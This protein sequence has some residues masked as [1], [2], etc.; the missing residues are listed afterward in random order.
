MSRSRVRAVSLAE[1][2]AARL[3]KMTAAGYPGAGGT[4]AGRRVAAAIGKKKTT[5]ARDG[6]S[7]VSS[8]NGGRGF[9]GY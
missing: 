3:N 5:S 6:T 7:P 1:V 4:A 9:A 8:M 2:E